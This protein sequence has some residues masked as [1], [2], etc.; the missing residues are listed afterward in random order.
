M[1]EMSTDDG[2]LAAL[3]KQVAHYRR[4]VDELA[5][6]N[7]RLDY[8]VSGLRNELKKKRQGF[9]LLSEL[10]LSIGAHKDISSIFD[11]TIRAINSTV[12]MDRTVVLRPIH[13]EHQYQPTQWIGFRDEW[14]ERF[15]ALLVE[16]PA[17]FAHGSG[18]LV[19]NKATTTTPLIATLRAAFELPY[20]ICL[21][22]MVDDAPI[23]LLLSGRLKEARPLY[24]P[25]DQGD[26]DTF[27]AIAG[28]ISASVRNMRVAVL[29]ETDR[30]KTEF[31]ANISHEFRTPITLTL[32]PLQQILAGRYGDVPP[33][34]QGQLGVMRR[35]QQRLL[36]LINQILDLAKLE[37][38]DVRLNV[39]PMPDLNRFVEERLDRFRS[40]AEERGI[41]VRTSLDPRV[42]AA[43][44]FVDREQ[45]D[46]LLV[47]LLSNAVK[48]THAGHIAVTTEL[49]D[50]VVR[51]VVSDT[52]VGIEPDQLPYIF[53]RFRQADGGVAREY[54]GSGIGL[55]LVKEIAGLHG[56]DVGV[57]SLYSSGTSFR[58]TLPLGKTH[59]NP[60]WIVE[61]TEENLARMAGPR[62]LVVDE[63]TA[64]RQDVELPNRESETAFDSKRATI[65]YAEDN[66]DLR[67]HVRDLLTPHYNVFLAID[68]RDGLEK[69]RHY[70]PDL[71]LSDQM[72]P[73][74]SGRDLLRAVRA[75]PELRST[76]VIFLTARAGTEARIETLDAG[77]DDYLAKPFDEGELLARVRV[78]LRARAQERELAAL[79]RRLEAKV[80]DQVAELVRSGELKRFLPRV[81]VDRVLNGHLGPRERFERRRITLLFADM[82]GSTD[83]TDHLEPEDVALL[84]NELL[85]EMTAVAIAHG[86]T[87][88]K[89]TGDGV[90]VLFGAAGTEGPEAQAWAA[91]EAAR[92][93]RAGVRALGA[94]WRR[95]GVDRDLDLRIGINTGHCT[96]GV[97]GSEVQQSYTAIG[98]P[99]NVA[100]RLQT[101]ASPGSIL[102]GF[103]TYALVQDQIRA[104]A[105]GLLALRGVARPIDTYEIL[106]PDGP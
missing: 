20:F 52:G 29:Q 65:L 76:P 17:D 39:A 91:V 22:V 84:I 81:V 21:P 59:L 41:E 31:F 87:V 63:G 55:A 82:V 10:Q 99:V 100:A 62:V 85:C 57:N 35:N 101:E 50:G 77:A 2:D 8:D 94:T 25:L 98:T 104:R 88:D 45:L 93:M 18:L 46:R 34:V 78:L 28:L 103:P 70:R 89:F 11:V 80:E 60:A 67:H 37:A 53:D 69:A 73:G 9:G 23:G 71:L 42:R 6:E 95:R 32:G 79:N 15:P 92:A 58:V 83:L 106:E 16:L 14:T 66:H 97:F 26:V 64:D 54:A 24:P 4:R 86:G 75:D 51:L 49:H 33:A 30:L 47:N 12:G 43:D 96:L 90:M 19:V 27:Q 68:G 7:L 61:F 56:G 72:M 102:C 3:Q 13:R 44:L 5:G 36:G 48:F 40:D 1:V 38:G 74:L 105:C